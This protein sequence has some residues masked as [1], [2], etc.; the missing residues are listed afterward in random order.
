MHHFTL[1]SIE[2][3]KM[4]LP[5]Q[6]IYSYLAPLALVHNESMEPFAKILMKQPI[7]NT[8]ISANTNGSIV[9]LDHVDSFLSGDTMAGFE[10]PSGDENEDE[11]EEED[12]QSQNVTDLVHA[13]SVR[14]ADV[15]VGQG[16]THRMRAHHGNVEFRQMV[17]SRFDAYKTARRSFKT[18]LSESI[19][20]SIYREN[21]R[22]LKPHEFDGGEVTVWKRL[23]DAKACRKVASSFRNIR[24]QQ[25][26][27]NVS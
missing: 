26:R 15:L 16:Q 13:D 4:T 12:N 21:G 11:D 20:Y 19:V 18:M 23:D 25:R 3:R 14:P 6:N 7:G 17:S 8:L 10:S 1:H 5:T 24:K 27:N 9:D 22:F 2:E